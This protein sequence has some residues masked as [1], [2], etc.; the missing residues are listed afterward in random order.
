[1][2]EFTDEYEV[3]PHCGY[4][5]STH[6][7]KA[8]QL[9]PGIML[10]E[11]YWI[12]IVLGSGGFGITY[13]AYDTKLN[14]I[15]AIKEYCP[16]DLVERDREGTQLGT[17]SDEHKAV[18][19]TELEHFLEE[20]RN[21]AK[22]SSHPNIVKVYHFFRENHTGYIVMEYLDGVSMKYFLEANDGRIAILY[23]KEIMLA[24]A[25]ALQVLHGEGILHRDVSPDNI[26]LCTDGK[27]KLI[28]FGLAGRA[29]IVGSRDILVKPGYAPPE[30][31]RP[32]GKQGTWTDIYAFGA[33]F[34]RAVTGCVP[35]EATDREQEDTLLRPSAYNAEVP[36]Y[37]DSVI[38]KAMALEIR[39]RFGRMEELV[40]AL[41]E[42]KVVPIPMSPAEKKER[43]HRHFLCKVAGGMALLF[44]ILLVTYVHL[45]QENNEPIDLDV[46]ICAKEGETVQNVQEYYQEAGRDFVGGQKNRIVLHFHVEEEEVYAERLRN[47]FSDG[48]APDVFDSTGLDASV[49]SHAENLTQWVK[50][51]DRHREYYFLNTYTQYITDGNRIPIGF[52][53]P[54]IYSLQSGQE[55]ETEWTEW[56]DDQWYTGKQDDQTKLTRFVEGELP[57]LCAELTEYDCI[58]EAVYGSFAQPREQITGLVRIA[59]MKDSIEHL[60]FTTTFSVNRECR[61]AEHNAAVSYLQYLLSEQ[62]QMRLHGQHTAV[63]ESRACS[64]NSVADR[65]QRWEQRESLSALDSIVEPLR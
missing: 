33:T 12:G 50:Q 38:L 3:C 62:G 35:E 57:Y 27:I 64:V 14:V 65:R 43:R 42:R 32:D 40:D 2:K 11:R 56:S 25:Q 60:V 4:V 6:E 46:W 9:E 20:A 49:L 45:R 54:V 55:G 23:A 16:V 10:Q 29:Q 36:A 1:M 13:K 28:D 61:R 31:Y 21:I 59:P 58:E 39:D 51:L 53:L 8:R 37:I 7:T 5:V 47:A 41:L 44:G 26:F 19:H 63:E 22:F 48:A 30:Q 24:V 34:Y 15:V 18:F 17:C 52:D